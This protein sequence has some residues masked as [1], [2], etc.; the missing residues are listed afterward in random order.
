MLSRLKSDGTMTGWG[1]NGF[2]K[3]TAPAGLSNVV[4]IATGD[5]HTLA[6]Q[7]NGKVNGLGQQTALARRT[8]PPH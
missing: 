8:Y 7:N 4:A 5:N 6:L 2:G 3:A 1:L